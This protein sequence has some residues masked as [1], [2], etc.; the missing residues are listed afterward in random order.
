[1]TETIVRRRTSLPTLACLVVVL[2][3]IGPRAAVDTARGTRTAS[4]T[5]SKDIAPVVFAKCGAC[6]YNGGPAPF[7]LLTYADA[8]RRSAQIAAVTGA[9]AMPPWKAEP[10]YGEFVG[11]QPL[12]DGEISLIRQWVDGGAVEGDARDLP[13]VPKPAEGWQLGKPDFVVTLPEPYT[14]PAE[15]RD[16]FRI[17][18][19]P[20]P[21][22]TRRYV[23]GVE[24]RSGNAQVVHHAQILLDPTPASRRLDDEDPAPGYEG[25]LAR[26]ATY[27]DGYLLG[28]TPGQAAPLLPRGLSWRLDPGM[29]L[30][31]K[32]HMNPSGRPERVQ[33]S[34]GFFFGEP[35]TRTPVMLRLGRQ[36]IDIPA[37]ADQY[38]LT[39]SYVLP[40]DV[41]VQAIQPHAH[42]RAREIRGIA[43]LPDGTSR[44]LIYIKDWDFR[45][46]HVYRLVSP[47][48]LP[49]GTT[50]AMRY[51]YDNSAQNVRN[52][53]VPPRRVQWGQGSWDEMGDLWIQVLTSD[54]RDRDALNDSFSRKAI[55]EDIVGYENLIRREPGTI[56]FHD[57]VALLY[58]KLGQS[59]AAVAHFEA[60]VRLAPE[61]AAAHFNLGTAL[62]VSGRFGEA[63]AAF[64]SA[65]RINP[66]YGPAHN[67][68]GELLLTRGSTDE[69]VPH[70]R[71]AVSVDDGNVEAH[72][73]LG[74]ALERRG[75]LREAIGEFRRAVQLRPAWA[76]ALANLA[77]LLATAP[78]EAIRD[79]DE[80]MRFA[81]QAATLTA[82]LDAQAL[83]VLAAACA[84]AGL[85]DRA[86]DI[87]EDALRLSP[88][89]PL[90]SGIRAR[91]DLYQRHQPYR[92]SKE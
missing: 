20:I 62:A 19:I 73:N 56:G 77:W 81:E 85:F 72:F 1:M 49:R 92:T 25:L 74:T 6:H 53:E 43:T 84:A 18:V 90:A 50:L 48:K 51:V 87:A 15:G 70:F 82:R 4:V 61:S 80:A 68:L 7:S 32:L 30:V 42:Y 46:Q 14:L 22:T 78:D 91:R 58:L 23:R 27:P 21:L 89:E 36:S 86:R 57:D 59:S 26:S 55:A 34:I 88:Q 31:V 40:V 79:A 39:D 33:P 3:A 2:A 60:S 24:F 71:A 29:D 35:P 65:L 37:G 75:E 76:S 10:G 12:T 67:N 47:L 64:E 66:V 28:W 13:P 8:R 54:D 69:A 44:W 38:V 17:F 41:E 16:V 83:D 5:F 52:P 11:Q 63:M 45:W 9:R